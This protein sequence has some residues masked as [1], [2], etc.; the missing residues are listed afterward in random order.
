MTSRDADARC[1]DICFNLGNPNEPRC[2]RRHQQDCFAESCRLVQRELD[3]R[4]GAIDGYD[5]RFIAAMIESVEPV[6]L[7]EIGCASGLST[8]ALA[9]MLNQLGPARILSFDLAD[10]FYAD[11]TRAVGFLLDGAPAHERVDVSVKTGCTS[12][13]VADHLDGPADFAFVDAAHKH[14]WPL[15]DTLA[16]LP[17]L[18]SGAPLLHHD[19]QMYRGDGF[20]ANGPKIL[21]D[22]LPA[23][24]VIRAGSLVPPG[25]EPVLRTRKIRDNI[26]AVHTPRD[27]GALAVRLADGFYIPWDDDPGKRVPE[28]FAERFSTFLRHHYDPEVDRAFTIGLKRYNPAAGR[29]S[30]RPAARRRLPGPIRRLL[31]R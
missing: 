2:A 10:R 27:P 12:L 4:N 24:V 18:R 13:D 6:Q 19:L 17:F 29:S 25:S 14:P 5:L 15:I 9:S 21:L 3:S 16:L 30:N 23:A 31:G 28:A 8:A 1:A 20:Y 26:F 7:V 11:P 22:Q